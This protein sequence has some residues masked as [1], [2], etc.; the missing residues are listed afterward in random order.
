[1]KLGSIPVRRGK[2]TRGYLE[3]PG[4]GFNVKVQIPVLVCAGTKPGPMMTVLSTQ[5][6]R[7]LNGIEAIRRVWKR[8]RP[9]RLRGTFVAV[10]VANL[11]ALW[12]RTQDYPFEQGRYLS[13]PAAYNLNRVWPGKTRGTLYEQMADVMWRAL[14]RR[15]DQVVD[16][17][18]WTDRSISFVWGHKRDRD[19]VRVFGHIA[20]RLDSKRCT[21]GMLQDACAR[22]KIPF[23]IAELTPQNALCE[24]SIAIGVRGVTNLLAHLGMID[25]P[26]ELPPEQYELESNT[27]MHSVNAE[28]EGLY[29]PAMEI[30]RP[31]HHGQVLGQVVAPDTLATVQTVRSPADGLLWSN[32]PMWCEPVPPSNLA[33]VGQSLAVVTE[34]ARVLRNA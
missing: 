28:R 17:H 25:G 19:R 3:M 6:G 8:L 14:V 10:P 7:E 31:V 21:P 16:L 26:V 13:R 22:A 24:A 2:R 5:H 34:V 27:P 20:H 33:D 4:Y 18:G 1:M 32:G 11:L 29:V 9:N 15:S 12:T 23:V 30:G